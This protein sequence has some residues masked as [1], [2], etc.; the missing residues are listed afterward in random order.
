MVKTQKVQWTMSCTLKSP[1]RLLVAQPSP[2][3]SPGPL[4]ATPPPNL[5]PRDS[6]HPPSRHRG[7]HGAPGMHAHSGGSTCTLCRREVKL[8]LGGPD[9]PRH[10]PASRDRPVLGPG[11][12]RALGSLSLNKHWCEDCTPEAPVGVNG[13]LL[14]EGG[15]GE[16]Q[17]FSECANAYLKLHSPLHKHYY[18]PCSSARSS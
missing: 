5:Q 1:A 2:L 12:E 15:S 11:L 8:L 17:P 9:L 14:P 13:I 18:T 16:S 6:A 7:L 10:R 3:L 4:E